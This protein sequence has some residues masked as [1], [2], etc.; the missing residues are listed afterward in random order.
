MLPTRASQ[1][2]APN[3]KAL[4]ASILLVAPF[5]RALWQA[6][7]ASDGTWL[8]ANGDVLLFGAIIAAVLIG[9]NLRFGRP[10]RS[11]LLILAACLAAIGTASAVFA[12]GV[13]FDAAQ[14]RQLGSLTAA[15]PLLTLACGF[16]AR[17]CLKRAFPEDVSR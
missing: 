9:D 2:T 11:F 13:Q 10:A 4:L 1:A 12:I 14:A 6:M 15:G 17:L 3:W 16:G 8:T 7:Q 5:L